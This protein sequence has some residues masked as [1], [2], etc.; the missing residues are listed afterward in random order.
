MRARVNFCG[1]NFFCRKKKKCTNTNNNNNN[2]KRNLFIISHFVH[3]VIQQTDA[4]YLPEKHRDV[5]KGWFHFSNDDDDDDTFEKNCKYNKI[6]EI[7]KWDDKSRRR[8]KIEIE[9]QQNAILSFFYSRKVV[10]WF[11]VVEAKWNI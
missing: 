11:D 1:R 3:L 10:A 5:T 2:K 9:K 8:M 4:T 6:N 7:I